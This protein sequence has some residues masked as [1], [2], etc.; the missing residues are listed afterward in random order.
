MGLKTARAFFVPDIG[1]DVQF[2]SE[3]RTVHGRFVPQNGPLTAS[4]LL[5]YGIGDRCHFWRH[6]QQ[7][8]AHAGVS[9]LVFDYHGHSRNYGAIA[10]ADTEANAADAYAWLRART[11]APRP[12]FLLGFSLG[13]GLAAEVAPTL[14]PPP[15]GVILS[16]AF[17]TLRQAARRAARPLSVLGNLIPDVWRTSGNIALMKMPVFII[18]SDGDAL[19]P[20]SM[21]DE[22]LNAARKGGAQAELQV[23]RSYPH[24]AVYR[25]VPEDYWAAIVDYI[26][27]TSTSRGS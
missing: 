11:P 15:A 10:S 20:V 18:H 21:A 25:R 22:L 1:V 23:F 26:E 5:F 7:R 6:A 16:E 8:L 4:V 17:T 14:S 27:R 19:F 3:G 13:S 12:V 2:S 24:D 9:S